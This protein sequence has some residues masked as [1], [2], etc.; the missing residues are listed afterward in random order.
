[1]DP[2]T[3][4]DITKFQEKLQKIDKELERHSKLMVGINLDYISIREEYHTMVDKAKAYEET[5]S[6]LSE[7]LKHKS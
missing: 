3:R 4:E 6:D 1:M 2:H 7:Q 5:Y